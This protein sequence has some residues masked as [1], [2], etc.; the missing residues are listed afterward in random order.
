MTY[1]HTHILASRTLASAIALASVENRK[2]RKIL[3]DNTV[4]WGTKEKS[5]MAPL[6]IENTKCSTNGIFGV[7]QKTTRQSKIILVPWCKVMVGDILKEIVENVVRVPGCPI[8]EAC[9][10]PCEEH[11]EVYEEIQEVVEPYV[12]KGK[13][14][15]EKKETDSTKILTKEIKPMSLKGLNENSGYALNSISKFI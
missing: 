7:G 10:I 14:I 11:L 9:T 5:Q 12:K 1:I 2:R 4:E 6:W 3:V 13:V 8:M 15:S